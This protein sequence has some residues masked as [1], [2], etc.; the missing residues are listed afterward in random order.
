LAKTIVS[1]TLKVS[2]VFFLIV[3]AAILC[4]RIATKIRLAQHRKAYAK[5]GCAKSVRIIGFFH[6]FCDAMGGGE[7]VLFQALKAI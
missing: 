1:C 6:P 7:K 4:V 2:F 5:E 3:G